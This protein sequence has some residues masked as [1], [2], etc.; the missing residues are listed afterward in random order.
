MTRCF[1]RYWKHILV[2]RR[3]MLASKKSVLPWRTWQQCH[4]C[5][6]I[7][8]VVV[9]W[10]KRIPFS[11]DFVYVS[12]EILLTAEII[13]HKTYFSSIICRKCWSRYHRDIEELPFNRLSSDVRPDV[14][15]RTTSLRKEF[16]ISNNIYLAQEHILLLDFD[17][18]TY[19]M[20]H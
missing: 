2:T 20:H 19:R 14:T 12:V 1:L 11:L 13:S 7:R 5:Y 9:S 10:P 8:F 18:Y 4:I 16:I 3:F 17:F 15:M 6:R